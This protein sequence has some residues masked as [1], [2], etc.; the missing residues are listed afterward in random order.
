MFKYYQEAALCVAYLEDWQDTMNLDALK[1][2]K[3]FTRGWTLQELIAPRPD[4]M[5]FFG[6]DWEVGGTK[7]ELARYIAQAT[8]IDQYMLNGTKE[9]T[10]FP[11]AVRFSWAAHRATKRR[12]DRAY[13]L[14]GIFGINMEMIYGEGDNAFLRLQQEIIKQST[15]MSIFAW[16]AATNSQKYMGLLAPS[17]DVFA[18]SSGLVAQR[19]ALLQLRDYSLTNRGI[20]FQMP[21]SLDSRT[22][23]F[24]LPINHGFGVTGETAIRERGVL[25][26]QVGTGLFVRARP[27][28]LPLIDEVLVWPE[29]D[30]VKT[31]T[32]HVK[33]LT[34][35]E[36]SLIDQRYLYIEKPTELELPWWGLRKVEPAGCWDLSRQELYAGHAG[37][38]LGHMHFSPQWAEEYDSFV[39]VCYF[40][41]CG[42]K[43]DLVRG[44]EWARTQ[45]TMFQQYHN[46]YNL[47]D[48]PVQLRL[49]HLFVKG[50]AKTVCASL[51]KTDSEHTVALRLEM[52][53]ESEHT[54]SPFLSPP[55]DP[56]AWPQR[57]FFILNK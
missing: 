55:Q 45:L 30:V 56:Y 21:L 32:F 24:V 54:T 22:G 49:P 37:V 43:C 3:W 16:M 11:V 42:W 48:T 23:F 34:P 35:S 27:E 9:I 39:L 15:D 33:M 13:S 26:R 31:K 6:K 25:L 51:R 12:E 53:E 8:S 7:L 17:P 14:L 19:F 40:A 57:P 28:E 36:S 4:K 46:G 29:A 47:H 38:F 10:D 44:D 1:N 52:N 41:E 5:L 2:C 18:K 50:V 20:K